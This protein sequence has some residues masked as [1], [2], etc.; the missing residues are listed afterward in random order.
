LLMLSKSSITPTERSRKLLKA[1]I[2]ALF[3]FLL[4]SLPPYLEDKFF[5][6]L[7]K[8]LTYMPKCAGAFDDKK[9]V[10]KRAPCS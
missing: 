1:R 10:I 4:F 6:K 2:S 3:C 8:L 7:K 9:H 5:I